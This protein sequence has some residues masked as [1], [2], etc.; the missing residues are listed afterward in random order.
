M[1]QHGFSTFESAVTA[2]GDGTRKKK[3][4]VESAMHSTNTYNNLFV[5]DRP[6]TVSH[7]LLQ[8]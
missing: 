2:N 3:H 6:D 4:T 7:E 8:L 1:S 5:E